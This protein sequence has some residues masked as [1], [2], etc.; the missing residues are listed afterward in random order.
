MKKKLKII[1]AIASLLMILA[2][3]YLLLY[4]NFDDD[5]IESEEDIDYIKEYD[6]NLKCYEELCVTDIEMNYDDDL[7]AYVVWLYITNTS[8][9]MIEAGSFDT[10]IYYND[11]SSQL[12]FW[13]EE[14]LSGDI[15]IVDFV[16]STINEVETVDYEL[17]KTEEY[18]LE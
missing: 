1:I 2:G 11:V 15:I 13:H 14:I 4:K 12:T 5:I 9:E 6:I 3:I 18:S 16:F 7:A 10:I 17:V 8:S